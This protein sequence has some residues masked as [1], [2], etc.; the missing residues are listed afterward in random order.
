MKTMY[1]E[2]SSLRT[3]KIMI[4]PRHINEIVCSW[5]RLLMKLLFLSS[6]GSLLP[7]FFLLLFF[8]DSFSSAMVFLWYLC[9]I[10]MFNFVHAA[11]SFFLLLAFFLSLV[12][13]PLQLFFCVSTC[14]SI[15]C[16]SQ[17]YVDAFFGQSFAILTCNGCLDS[18]CRSKQ[19]RY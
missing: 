8:Y 19:A 16:P 4:I 3:L 15:C 13:S 2:T 9:N 6:I 1:T 11:A 18:N 12:I 14:R 17:E 5:I 10:I 7:Y